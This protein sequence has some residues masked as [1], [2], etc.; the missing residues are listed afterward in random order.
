MMCSRQVCTTLDEALAGWFCRGVFARTRELAVLQVTARAGCRNIALARTQ[1]VACVFG[2]ETY[3]RPAES[4][5][6]ALCDHSRRP[7]CSSLNLAAVQVLAC[8]YGWRQWKGARAGKAR[9]LAV[10]ARGFLPTSS[11][12]GQAG[13]FNPRQK[14]D[15]VAATVCTRGSRKV[16][17]LRSIVKAFQGRKLGRS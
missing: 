8:G 7:K 11:R 13:F 10:C 5:V 12:D 3:G 1:Q 4:A 9:Q 2:N 17:I 14:T 6:P 15:A 16:N